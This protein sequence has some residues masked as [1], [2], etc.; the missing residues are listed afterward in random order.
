[1]K[2]RVAEFFEAT[3]VVL[4]FVILGHSAYRNNDVMVSIY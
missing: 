4:G 1:M 3:P 2:K